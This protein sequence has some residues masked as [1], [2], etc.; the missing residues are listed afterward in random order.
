MGLVG[1]PPILELGRLQLHIYFQQYCWSVQYLASEPVSLSV[2]LEPHHLSQDCCAW[3]F[4]SKT[5]I[6]AVIPTPMLI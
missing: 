3:V 5:I 2:K 1:S 6:S 4:T